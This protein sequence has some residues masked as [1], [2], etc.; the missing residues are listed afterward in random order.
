MFT[1]GMLWCKPSIPPRPPRRVTF[2]YA[3]TKHITFVSF[4][5]FCF[6]NTMVFR[7]VKFAESHKKNAGRWYNYEI[8]SVALPGT[9]RVLPGIVPE[10]TEI[11]ILTYSKLNLRG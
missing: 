11:V 5:P 2:D 9:P 1:K 3:L 6:D 10:T 4:I 8:N 7:S